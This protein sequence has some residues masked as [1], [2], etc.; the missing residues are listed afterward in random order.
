[1]HV[2]HTASAAES[3]VPAAKVDCSNAVLAE[4][5]GAHDARLDGDI[6]VGLVEDADGVLGQ[7]ASNGNEFGVSGAIE[8]AIGL[9]HSTPDDLAVLHENTTHRRLV[10]GQGKLGLSHVIGQFGVA[11]RCSRSAAEARGGSPCRWLPA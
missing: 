10:T 11:K 7:D 1:V 6:E 5:R 8:G 9:V 3:L 4:H 2:Q